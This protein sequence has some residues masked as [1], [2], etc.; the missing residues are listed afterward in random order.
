MLRFLPPPFPLRHRGVRLPRDPQIISPQ[1][2]A[3]IRRRRYEA[4]EAIQVETLLRDSDRVME[5]GAGLGLISTIAARSP[6]TEAVRS[7]EADPRL[8]PYIR[9]VHALNRIAPAKAELRNRVLTAGP[10]GGTATFYVRKNFWGSSLRP[11]AR[12]LKKEAIPTE[13]IAAAVAEFRPTFLVCDIEGGE[14]ELFDGIALPC[15]APRRSRR[16]D[17]LAQV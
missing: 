5:L 16:V 11:S 6:L 8:I 10:G 12:Y 13:N 7:Y 2:A 15:P 1:I 17:L 14:V 9:R 3:S 4:R